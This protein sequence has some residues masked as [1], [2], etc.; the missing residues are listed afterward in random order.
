M[1]S[2]FSSWGRP[3]WHGSAAF[4]L[5][6]TDSTKYNFFLI[7]DGVNLIDSAYFPKAK[8]Y[9]RLHKLK[10]VFFS[11]H[12]DDMPLRT[13]LRNWYSFEYAHIKRELVHYVPAFARSCER[14]NIEDLIAI[15]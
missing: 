15:G 5:K 12:A 2:T 10:V 1:P 14:S 9:C 6:R 8:I 7:D 13:G 11:D 4:D 3:F